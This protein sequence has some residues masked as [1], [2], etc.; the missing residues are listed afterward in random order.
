MASQQELLLKLRADNTE[1]KSKLTDAERHARK[2]TTGMQSGFSSLNFRTFLYGTFGLYAVQR[3]LKAT[4]KPAM[5]F[6]T[7]LAKVSTMLD[8]TSMKSMTRFQRGLQSLSV[9]FGESTKTLSKGLYDILSASIAPAKAMS[10]LKVSAQAAVAGMTTTA[11]AAD[12]ITTI[13]NSYGM[14]AERADHVS[15]V[16]FATVKRGKTEFPELATAIGMVAATAAQVGLSFEEM[17]AAVSTMTRQGINVH[18]STIALMN[19]LNAFLTPTEAAREAAEKFGIQLTTTWLAAN[20]FEGM[21][22]MLKDATA[23]QVAEIFPS[24]RGLRGMNAALGDV[25]GFLRD[26]NLNMNSAGLR[27]EA[28]GKMATTAQFNLGQFKQEMI[29]FAVE[30]GNQFLPLIT[31]MVKAMRE[32]AEANKALINQDIKSISNSM[33]LFAESI[34]LIKIGILSAVAYKLTAIA[35]GM[36]M[37]LALSARMVGQG[38]KTWADIGMAGV[39]LGVAQYTPKTGGWEKSLEAQ[40]TKSAQQQFTNYLD[41]IK[42]DSFS[43]INPSTGTRPN[44]PPSIKTSQM[45][46]SAG[47]QRMMDVMG[48]KGNLRGMEGSARF[49]SSQEFK[50]PNYQRPS[51]EEMAKID[52]KAMEYS[53]QLFWDT[54]LAKINMTKT[55]VEQQKAV[56]DLYRNQEIENMMKMPETF[57]MR[58]ELELQIMEKYSLQKQAIVETETNR[59]SSMWWSLSSQMSNAMAN[60]VMQSGNAFKNIANAFEQM[61]L[62]MAADF[63]AKAVIFTLL[64]AITGGKA[65]GIMKLSEFIF[66]KTTKGYASGG[67]AY[68]PQL[69]MVG[70]NGAERILNPEETKA[71]NKN[72][73]ND[74]SRLTV[75]FNGGS[76]PNMDIIERLRTA[77]RDGELDFLRG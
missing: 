77:Q 20:K 18:R 53:K 76:Q 66:P 54:E 41:S 23:E 72:V 10:V 22:V 44:Y 24:V 69:A 29:V 55:G 48:F 75:I 52:P 26:L 43:M 5:E 47:S 63:A 56:L 17:Q 65:F 70:E 4:M 30:I 68:T 57:G 50:A 59:M 31:K 19:I 2:T 14:A 27:M 37:I 38:A 64:Q 35:G 45:V 49:L 51:M 71:Y 34:K 16:L 62:K 25:S 8:Q 33:I 12:A 15:N 7:Q 39:P 61:L 60:A 46:T 36:N 42:Q 58:K 6:Q 3:G 11:V 40:K 1:L 21:M 74:N 9:Q 13:L 32:W 28:F 67:M 73:S